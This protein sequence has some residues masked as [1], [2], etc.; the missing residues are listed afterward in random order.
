MFCLF[1]AHTFVILP[2]SSPSFFSPSTL[3]CLSPF[4]PPVLSVPFPALYLDHNAQ[5]PSFPFPGF[6]ATENEGLHF[7]ALTFI[8]AG[9]S[10]EM[11]SVLKKSLSQGAG[12]LAAGCVIKTCRLKSW[13]CTQAL[14]DIT[15]CTV[16]VFP[17][18]VFNIYYCKCVQPQMLNSSEEIHSLTPLSSA[19][20]VCFLTAFPPQATWSVSATFYRCITLTHVT[21]WLKYSAWIMLV[22]WKTKI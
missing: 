9:L 8:I 16:H 17:E 3:N 5:V 6:Q 15:L 2:G 4:P 1:A 20:N 22:R 13:H 19:K 18:I 14:L 11:W 10:C 7:Y 12:H 21:C